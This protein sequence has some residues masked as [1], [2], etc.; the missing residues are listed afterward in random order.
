MKL[1]VRK[2]VY[3]VERGS[4]LDLILRGTNGAINKFAQEIGNGLKAIAV[5]LSTPGDNS[6]MVQ[7]VIDRL[8]AE[9]NAS[10][11]TV[12]DALNQAKEN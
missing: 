10:S 11:N 5:A 12:E 7:A 4:N 2:I 1:L 6:T 8:A 9:I 3:D